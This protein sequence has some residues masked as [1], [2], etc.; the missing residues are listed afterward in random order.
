MGSKILFNI[1]VL[2]FYEWTKLH[3]YTNCSKML[4]RTQHSFLSLLMFKAKNLPKICQYV[5]LCVREGSKGREGKSVCKWFPWFL[6]WSFSIF[7][8]GKEQAKQKNN[9][10]KSL[11][12]PCISK[13]K[14]RWRAAVFLVA[15]K[16]QLEI[17]I[18]WTNSCELS[19]M[20][21]AKGMRKQRRKV[22][23]EISTGEQVGRWLNK[24]VPLGLGKN[25]FH[26]FFCN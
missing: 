1:K 24:G 9:K 17:A 13:L 11:P 3:I 6:I 20:L 19:T 21:G 16:I 4:S 10:A 18:L 15:Q 23:K 2:R 12:Q 8:K 25:L 7:G 14:G 22:R 26:T 5:S